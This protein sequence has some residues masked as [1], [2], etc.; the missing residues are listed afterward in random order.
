MSERFFRMIVGAWILV[1]LFLGSVEVIY[2]LAAVLL[3]EG[4]TNQRLP[5]LVSKL[6][7]GKEW[8]PF[9]LKDSRYSFEAERVLRF[10]VVVFVVV[11]FQ[12]GFEILWWIPWFFGFAILGAGLAGI[13]PIVISLR[14]IGWS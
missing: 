1:G 13:C 9:Q 4:V 7:Y 14:F 10:I 12:P 2:A 5:T 3:F 8:S 6:R 11:P